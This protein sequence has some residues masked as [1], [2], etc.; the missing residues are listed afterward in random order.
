[1]LPDPCSLAP[2]S[3]QKSTPP[4]EVS[5]STS[6]SLPERQV[7]G[8]RS[9][10]VHHGMEQCPIGQASRFKAGRGPAAAF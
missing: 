2:P 10:G 7:E 9:S 4:Q 5:R 1:M 6:S 3:K 8:T